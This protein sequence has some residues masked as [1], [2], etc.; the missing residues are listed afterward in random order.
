MPSLY[1]SSASKIFFLY[2]SSFEL[3]S[4]RFGN[5]LAH[6]WIKKVRAL[7]I[8]CF[9]I[10]DK[11]FVWMLVNK[12]LFTLKYNANIIKSQRLGCSDCWVS[13]VE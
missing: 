3:Y 8:Y 7:S 5:N 11:G 1:K 10:S 2:A 6:S 4:S 12:S 13:L 9:C